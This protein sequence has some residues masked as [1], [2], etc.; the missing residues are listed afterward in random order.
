MTATPPRKNQLWHPARGI[1]FSPSPSPLSSPA[2]SSNN[3]VEVPKVIRR[4]HDSATVRSVGTQTEAISNT[5]TVSGQAAGSGLDLQGPVKITGGSVSVQSVPGT[6]TQLK[7]RVA[8]KPE[9]KLI[10]TTH[11]PPPPLLEYQIVDDLYHAAKK[12]P[13]GSPKSFWSYSQYR[14]TAKDGSSHAVKVHY[15]TST[16]TMERVCKQYFMNEKIIG[17]DLE[18]MVDATKSDGPRRNVSLIQIASVSR[19]GL[20]HVALFPKV[21]DLVGPSFRS[22][23]ENPEVTKLGVSIKGDCT[24]L[25]NFLDVDSRGLMELSHM[26]RLVTYSRDRQYHL[27]NRRLVPL[28]KQVEEYLHLPLFKGEDVRASDWSKRLSWD[29]VTYAASDAYV[30]LHLYATLEHYRKQLDPCPPHP[31][32]A[33]L[34]RAIQ[35]AAGVEVTK[36]SNTLEADTVAVTDGCEPAAHKELVSVEEPKT[37]KSLVP[38]AKSAPTS[39]TTKPTLRP[40]DS[41]IEVAEDRVASYRASHSQTRST[42][43][44]L[45]SYF[46]WHCYDLSPTVIAELL[47]DPPLKT[48][49]VVGY[50]LS[51]VQAEKLPVDRD[52]LR[53]VADFVPVS[54]LRTRWPV[55]MGMI[56]TPAS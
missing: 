1:S 55:V 46:L 51:V 43:A 54:K 20:F 2:Q 5:V 19:V 9:T 48:A 8:D 27:I 45:R 28:A 53:E 39:L 50:I 30:A 56:A 49:T 26:Y 3:L 7:K 17:F 25:R 15:C 31:Y 32:H 6:K 52:R 47:R 35:L 36:P 37:K 29:Q 23:M 41:R 11:G 44:E 10:K 22:L 12:A 21:E 33:E 34:D 14:R 42:F 38:K 4:F 18:W 13:A 24:R 40:K 16:H